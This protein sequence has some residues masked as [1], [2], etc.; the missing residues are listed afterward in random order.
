MFREDRK[1]GSIACEDQLLAEQ[2][3]LFM[4]RLDQF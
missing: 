4:F 3:Q 2:N 1:A